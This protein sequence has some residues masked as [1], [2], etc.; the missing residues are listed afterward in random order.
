M[1]DISPRKWMQM[2]LICVL[3]VMMLGA[4]QAPD[5]SQSKRFDRIGHKMMCV[6]GCG[7]VL[8]DCNHVGCPDSSRMIGELREQMS[9]PAVSG[10]DGNGPDASGPGG[11]PADSLILNWFIAKYGATVLSAPIR[12]GFDNVAW[13]IP[14]ALFLLATVGTAILVRMWAKRGTSRLVA[15]DASALP[16][17]DPVRDRIR[18]ETEY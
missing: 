15:G 10:P 5:Q 8:L 17:D 9:A 11:A 6:C 2:A 1:P 14:V 18:R 3:A 16:S 4:S 13:G 12:G 7:Q